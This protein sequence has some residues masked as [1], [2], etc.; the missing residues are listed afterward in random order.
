M[1]II[2]DMTGG[3]TEEGARDLCEVLLIK[4]QR[5]FSNELQ[6]RDGKPATRQQIERLYGKCLIDAPSEETSSA[7]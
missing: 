1:T 2:I 5:H 6:A 4:S 3:V 7:A